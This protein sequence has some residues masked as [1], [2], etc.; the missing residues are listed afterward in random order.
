MEDAE[1]LLKNRRTNGS[2]Y[3]AGFAV[4]C[5]LKALIMSNSTRREREKLG[6]ALK[7]DFGH[8]LEALRKEAGRRG[9]H[10]NREV[11]VEFRRLAAW[12]NN[13]RYSAGVQTTEDAKALLGAAEV[14]IE[15]AK[16]TARGTDG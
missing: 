2:I 3:L 10:M 15:W 4:E 14:V 1:I 11:M 9:I 16:R 12:D 7:Q 6:V 13:M 5:I 8:D